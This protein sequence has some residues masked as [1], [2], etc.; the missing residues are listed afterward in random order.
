MIQHGVEWVRA[1]MQRARSIGHRL[2]HFPKGD[3][4]LDCKIAKC[5]KKRKVKKREY[6]LLER[7]LDPVS[8]LWE[9]IA[10]DFIVV[11]K[12][13]ESKSDHY[14]LMIRDEWSGFLL[15]I[16]MFSRDGDLIVSQILGPRASAHTLVCKADVAKE[17]E[18]AAEQLGALYSQLWKGIGHTTQ[19]L[20]GTFEPLR[21][22]CVPL[23]SLPPAARFEATCAGKGLGSA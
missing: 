13:G 4:C 21:S 7:G 17:F 22:Q 3:Q 11:G 15:G 16:P 12:T 23:T 10:I 14:V 9:R 6:E 8:G 20:R 19:G 18:Y 5:Y 2:A 1:E